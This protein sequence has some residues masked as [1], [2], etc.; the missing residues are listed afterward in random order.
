ML[1]VHGGSAYLFAMADDDGTKA[2]PGTK[3][4]TLPPQLRGHRIQVLGENR[5]ITPNPGGTFQDNFAALTSYHVYKI[6]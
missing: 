6:G 5:T 4:F 2:G 3:T 1:K